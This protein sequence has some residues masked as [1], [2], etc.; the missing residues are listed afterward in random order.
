MA[1][2][3]ESLS[4]PDSGLDRIILVDLSLAKGL[5]ERTRL[6]PCLVRILTGLGE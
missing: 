6:E 4:V 2:D 5:A 1:I 3:I